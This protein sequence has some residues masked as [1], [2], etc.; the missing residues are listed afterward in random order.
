MGGERRYKTRP[1]AE[2]TLPSVPQ[3]DPESSTHRNLR[4]V[5]YAVGFALIAAGIVIWALLWKYWPYVDHSGGD[6]GP[7]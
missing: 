3:A 5:L 6:G 4:Y 7:D 1:S 2:G